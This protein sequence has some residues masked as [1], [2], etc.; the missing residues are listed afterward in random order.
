MTAEIYTIKKPM[1]QDV[2]L[3]MLNASS[4]TYLNIHYLVLGLLNLQT[5]DL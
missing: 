5:K 3:K 4:K 2:E 1:T